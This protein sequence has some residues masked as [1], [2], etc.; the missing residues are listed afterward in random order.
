MRDE[1]VGQTKKGGEYRQGEG[2]V[3]VAAGGK[4]DD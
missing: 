1:E 2:V 4:A 3:R